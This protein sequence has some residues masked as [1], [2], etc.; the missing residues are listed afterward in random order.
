MYVLLLSRTPPPP[1]NK[2]SKSDRSR[3]ENLLAAMFATSLLTQSCYGFVLTSLQQFWTSKLVPRCCQACYKFV[4]INLVTALSGQRCYK[5]VNKLPQDC[6]N[7]LSQAVR[8]HH[9]DKLLE[10]HCYKFAA[11]LLQLVRFYACTQQ[12]TK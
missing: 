6:W 1:E 7:K 12:N 2:R 3:E 5:F 9:G 8:T 4:D 10:Q 11:G